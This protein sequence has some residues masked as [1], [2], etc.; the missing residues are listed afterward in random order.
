MAAPKPDFAELLTFPTSFVF[1]VVGEAEAGLLDAVGRVAR[2]V[3]GRDDARMDTRP[4]SGG[5]YLAV[6]LRVELRDLRELQTCYT[7]LRA[8]PGVRL[9]L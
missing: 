9:V 3:L 1:R 5:R 2:E 8:L 7:R 6:H 4:S